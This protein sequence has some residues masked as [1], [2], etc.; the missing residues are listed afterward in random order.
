MSLTVTAAWPVA[1]CAAIVIWIKTHERPKCNGTAQH[2]ARQLHT[3]GLN[4]RGNLSLMFA[5]C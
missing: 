4:S 3:T 1:P 2:H 5:C